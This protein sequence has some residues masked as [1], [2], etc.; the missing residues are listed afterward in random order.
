[1]A[2]KTRKTLVI[3]YLSMHF[4]LFTYFCLILY[5]FQRNTSGGHA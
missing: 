1:L 5:F 4:M 2:I 3:V